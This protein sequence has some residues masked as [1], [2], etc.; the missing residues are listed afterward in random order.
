MVNRML[1]LMLD[2]W[3]LSRARVVVK[4]DD[5]ARANQKRSAQ[6]FA[7]ALCVTSKMARNRVDPFL[8]SRT[9]TTSLK[10]RSNCSYAEDIVLVS[11][12]HFQLTFV[13]W[14]GHCDG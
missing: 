2:R 5:I 13:D 4:G 7:N 9:P 1:M 3:L 8:R 10:P 12:G 6:E 14:S 11:R